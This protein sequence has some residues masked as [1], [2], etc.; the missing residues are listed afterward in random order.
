MAT[1]KNKDILKI[2]FPV[3]FSMLVEQ[4]L[5]IT[6][7]AFLGRLSEIELGASAIGGV[8]SIFLFMA[9]FGFALG[10]QIII[11]RRNGEGN[12]KQI[13]N[14]FY[15]GVYFQVVLAIF[16]ILFTL[17]CVPWILSLILSSAQIC[18][19]A[20]NYLSWRTLGFVFAGIGIMYRSFFMGTVQTKVLMPAS[21]VMVISNCLFNYILIFG[22]FGFPQLGITGAAIGTSLA[23][24]VQLIYYIAYTK[25]R[26]QTQKYGLNTM[27]HINFPVLRQIWNLSV[28]TM[29][30][31]ICSV[32]TWFMFYLFIEHL[33][34]KEIA[35]TKIIRGMN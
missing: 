34:E 31:N 12:Y 33:G 27:P 9:S 23:E 4:L 6:D 7:N 3:L 11:G 13:G 28:W 14:I 35:V 15:Q 18:S 1:Y 32:G 16:V 17:F 10:S 30:Q 29:I 26:I 2:T 21:V 22:K 19:A 20:I 24:L 8:F 25:R 5:T